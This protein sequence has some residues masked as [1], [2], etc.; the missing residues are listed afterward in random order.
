M[1]LYSSPTPPP[2]PD[3]AAA[4]TAGVQAD[5]ATLPFRLGVNAAA[6]NGTVYTDPE[7]GKVYD[8]R[9]TFDANRFFSQNPEAKAQYD[10]ENKAKGET[11]DPQS[12]AN[13]Y[14]TNSGKTGS[15][16]NYYTGSAAYRNQTD[17]DSYTQLLQSGQNITD[18]S[19]RKQ[20]DSLLGKPDF[21]KYVTSHPDLLAAWQASGE[22]DAAKWGEQHYNTFGKN[23][24]RDLPSS[25]LLKQFNDLNLD[26]QKAAWNAALDASKKGTFA[27]ADW[28][29]ELLPKLN[30]LSLSEQRK[31]FDA[32]QAANK[33][34]FS[35]NLDQADEAARRAAAS[36]TSTLPGLNNLS[37]Q[38]QRQA[39]LDADATGRA[40]NPNLYGVRD[41]FAKQLQDELAAGSD[42][43]K[44]QRNK[45]QQR[46]RGA[47]ASRGNILGD[48]AAFDEAIAESDYAQNLV[49]DRRSQALGLIN[50]RDLSP[51]FTSLGVVNPTQVVAPNNNGANFSVQTAVNPL[52]PN[53]TATTTAAPNV[54]ATAIPTSNP[55]SMMNPNAGQSGANYG[56]SA[57]QTTTQQQSQQ[58]NPWMAGLGLLAGTALGGIGGGVGSAL[59]KA[60]GSWA[61]CW[62]ARAVLGT[63]TNRWRMFRAWLLLEAPPSFRA[64]YIRQ[65]ARFADW[66]ENKP[67]VAALLR[68]F[69]LDRAQHMEALA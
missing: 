16:L 40:V 69:F 49:N 24:G 13:D 11:R 31:G 54:T 60:A 9:G 15:L 65:G 14:L 30:A 45:V 35:A 28:Q 23:E 41:T 37:L 1:G 48:G 50:S 22:P 59:G 7:T 46:I 17:A 68:P 67:G 53:F 51:N 10:A 36:Q 64:R 38:M 33:T 55:L 3:Y 66:L 58:Q 2:A 44:A 34:A 25:G 4:T 18:A 39:T 57:W 29:A 62:V 6:Q 21:Q 27:Q 42:L 47:Q 32:T 12:F 52:M 8:F 19:T 56:L 63:E 20:L 5:A 61:T 26:Q 43:T